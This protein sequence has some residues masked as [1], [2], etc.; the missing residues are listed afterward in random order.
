[1]GT[2]S[3][4]YSVVTGAASGI[5]RDVARRLVAEGRRVV[6]TDRDAAGLAS[7]TDELGDAVLTDATLDVSDH[8]A[9]MAWGERL[10]AEHGAPEEVFHVAGIAIWGDPT[11]LPHDKWQRVIDVNLMGTVNVVE[12]L[13]PAM[14]DAP[15]LDGRERRRW[16]GLLP[17]RRRRRHLCCVSSAAGFLGLPWHAAYA[18]SKGGVLGLCEVLRFDLAPSGIEVH[19]A[20]PGAV[21]TP[22]VRTIDID[23]V[24]QSV[25]R[26]AK[27]KGLFQGLAVTPAEAAESLVTGV[28]RG[29]YLIYTS[30]DIRLGRWAQVNMPWAYRGVMRLLNRGLRWAARDA[31]VPRPAPE[32]VAP[33]PATEA[34]R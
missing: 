22:L 3:G 21:D 5:G 7:L 26:V 1:M 27:A 18:A 17:G 14:A 13:V 31:V 6:T 8:D 32:A 24:D 15:V 9:V 16:F 33:H 10:V 20:V 2:A 25:S 23:G 34:T 29:R 30:A 12:A 19:V 11:R 4:S 28:R